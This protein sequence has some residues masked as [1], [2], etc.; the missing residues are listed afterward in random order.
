VPELGLFNSSITVPREDNTED[1]FWGNTQVYVAEGIHDLSELP[2]G[3]IWYPYPLG[4]AFELTVQLDL[5]RYAAARLDQDVP[6][7]YTINGQTLLEICDK[8]H[9][10]KLKTCLVKRNSQLPE[11]AAFESSEAKSGK[12]NSRWYRRVSKT[13]MFSKTRHAEQHCK[14]LADV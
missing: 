4:S 7:T 9:H 1:L 5:H 2:K 8:L 10:D 14:P 13:I 11:N 3:K 6:I 12:L